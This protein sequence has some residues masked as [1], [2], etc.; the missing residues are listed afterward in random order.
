VIFLIISN[1]YS[2]ISAP[3]HDDNFKHH[4]RMEEAMK[5]KVLF[6]SVLL[7]K[8]LGAKMKRL[9]L[10]VALLVIIPAAQASKSAEV[11][12]EQKID[13]LHFLQPLGDDVKGIND[14]TLANYITIIVYRYEDESLYSEVART[15]SPKLRGRK[16]QWNWK[17]PKADARNRH[18]ITIEVAELE[19]GFVEIV[20]KVGRR[21]PIK[22]FLEANPRIWV[23]VLHEQGKSASESANAL[24]SEFNLD[25]LAVASLLMDDGYSPHEVATV[26]RDVFALGAEQAAQVL[27]DIGSSY[28]EVGEV[29]HTVFGMTDQEEAQLLA[30]LGFNPSQIREVLAKE[31][32]L[33]DAQILEILKA[34]GFT[35]EELEEL[36]SRVL[37]ERFAPQ[38][39]FDLHADT[40]PMSAQ[41]FFDE[42]VVGYRDCSTDPPENTD[43][44]SL[45]PPGNPPPTY[46]EAFLIKNQVRIVYWWFYGD[47][48]GCWEPI[49]GHDGDHAG[50]WERVI[51]T[52]TEDR[53]KVAAVTFYQHKGWYTRLAEGGD[54]DRFLGANYDDPGLTF[55]GLHPIVYVGWTQHG[56]YHD[57]DGDSYSGQPYSS[58]KYFSDRRYNLD[59]RHLRLSTEQNLKS[60]AD[61]EEDWMKEEDPETNF[62]LGTGD[63]STKTF[64]LGSRFVKPDTLKI[65]ADGTELIQE[66]DF[67]HIPDSG[68]GSVDQVWFAQAPATGTIL[69]A[70]YDRGDF[71]WG[72]I[73]THPVTEYT[74][75]DIRELRSCR[76]M[77][78]TEF[79]VIRGCFESQCLWHDNQTGWSDIHPGTCSH[80]PSGYTDLGVICE[81]GFWPWEISTRAITYYNI[82]TI[83]VPETDSGLIKKTP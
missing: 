26:L 59:N 44:G 3:T 33:T 17:V 32:G 35:E 67:S 37:A 53:S 47:Q 60:I 77:H 64:D 65:K 16:F 10:I 7:I 48:P 58:C 46:Y 28:M 82:N 1:L 8:S 43:S 38:L 40:F 66:K 13:A 54:T 49:H 78:A 76:G 55:L 19:V 6:V 24:V 75:D 18:R 73:G 71:L 31:F 25:A 62:P 45:G 2:I 34:V 74:T 68:V 70:D 83:D 41:T 72:E 30:D 29:L 14:E 51:V 69:A 4:N 11:I 57:E 36:E 80:C 9:T 79:G 15:S 63:G 52:L 5:F 12:D 42:C 39:R 81:K 27:L 61:L 22:F 23:R 21:I 20:P 50:D 56:S